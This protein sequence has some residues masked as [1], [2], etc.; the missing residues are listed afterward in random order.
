MLVV[1]L[2]GQFNI[3]LNDQLIE[4]PSRPA[5]TLFAYLT[6]HPGTA[7]RREMLAGLIWPEANESNARSNLRH[8]LWRI[9]KAVGEPAAQDYFSADDLT[10]A[11]NPDPGCWIDAILLGG[12]INAG[13]APRTLEEQVAAYQGEL[14]PGFYDDW[15]T[16]ERERLQSAFESKIEALIDRLGREKHWP[17]VIE[18]AGHWIKFG[19]A[20]EPAYR[21]LMTAHARAGHKAKVKEA[22][23]RCVEALQRE[24]GVEPSDETQALYQ[25]LL[26][27]RPVA[28]APLTETL[29]APRHNLPAQ[30]TPLIGREIEL[31]EITNRLV[32]D[33]GCRLLTIVGPGGVGKT[34]LALHTA[35]QA[36]EQFADGTFFVP[37][38]AIAATEALAPAILLALSSAVQDQKDP[39]VQLI[40]YL[41]DKQVLL[42]LDNLEHL[43]DGAELIGEI[44]STAPDVKLMVTSRERLH[45]QWEW[46]Y[47]IQGLDYPH[48]A[49]EA[50]ES[51][52]AVQL[53]LQTARRMRARFSLADEQPHVIR[54]CQ[55]VEGLPLGLELAASW[56]RV[57]SCQ[58]IAQQIE[59]NLDLLS[60][61]LQDVPDRHRSA[62]AV[63]EYSWSLLAPE[64][65][66][67]LM[68]LATFPGGFRRGAAEKVTGAPLSLL[69]TLVDKSLLRVSAAGRYDMHSLLRQYAA[70][71]LAQSSQGGAI[72]IRLLNYYRDYAQE[73]QHDYAVLEDERINVMTC[74]EIA[75]RNWQAQLVMDYAEALSEMWSA[76]G[77][78]S[79][80]RKGYAWA[81]DAAGAHDDD[82]AL[83]KYLRQW[84]EACIEQSDYV[85]A[86]EHLERSLQLRTLLSD[87][88]EIANIQYDLARVALDTSDHA[89]AADLLDKAFA[90]YEQLKDDQGIA[91]TLFMQAWL[92]YDHG[93]YTQAH[94]L[95]KQALT[96]Q[97]A[98]RN[99]RKCVEILRLLANIAMHGEA[100]YLAAEQYCSRAVDLCNATGES[101]ELAVTLDV[102]AETYRLQGKLENA[103][104]ETEKSLTLTRQM[105]L[106][107]SQAIDL[108]RLSKIDFDRGDL[109]NALQEGQ[110]SLSLCRALQDRW[111]MIYVLDHLASILTRL[112]DEPQSR[113]LWH[114]AF[115]LAQGLNH[116]LTDHLRERL[117]S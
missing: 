72:Q 116:P 2:L 8:A 4:I 60:V 113:A 48:E 31:A 14:L 115:A 58:E 95:A 12:K 43:L 44:L 77:H 86:T 68:K 109:Q 80:A 3:Q 65:Q 23:Q 63:F 67:V 6:L 82:R 24:F 16:I 101:G 98:Q 79:D 41:R 92:Y 59:H 40:D 51:Y 25:Q 108:F 114:E 20:P 99:P 42:I 5:Q 74:L 39:R 56:V 90:V 49:V 89:Q 102:L 66:Q 91:N 19:T 11:F 53:F 70:E 61:Q 15:I 105:G 78:W 85:E 75:Q 9:R 13:P 29:S 37:F 45:L 32:N 76:R 73:H 30:A 69:F 17:D 18:W 34:R 52:S 88:R 7:F 47:E 110:Q 62:R 84:G 55:L 100:D 64:E 36:L 35:A 50:V 54:I 111:G 87:W 46:L 33:P 1:K 10:L 22:Y 96:I 81:C 83:A 27:T 112:N 103:R 57:M 21:A 71:K 107:K 93:D 26:T 94:D 104:L 28:Q 106:R 38:E 97:E 117:A